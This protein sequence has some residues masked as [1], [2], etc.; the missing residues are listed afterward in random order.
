M[1]CDIYYTL[2]APVLMLTVQSIPEQGSFC[3][4]SFHLLLRCRA[5]A[6]FTCPYSDRALFFA[7]LHPP[8]PRSCAVLPPSSHSIS[9]YSFSAPFFG[10][11]RPP[12]CH[13]GTVLHRFSH[14]LAPFKRRPSPVFVRT[15]SVRSPPF[16]GLQAVLPR[17][18]TRLFSV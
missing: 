17:F 15:S 8:F 2:C 5:S 1:R 13:S 10:R 9:P 7:R 12:L 4:V 11:L 6:V 3:T 18:A 14:V 16:I